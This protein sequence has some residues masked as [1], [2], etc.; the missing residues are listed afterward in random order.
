MSGITSEELSAVAGILLSL[1]FSYIPGVRE[2]FG[3][4]EPTYKRLVMLGLLLVSALGIFS[5]SCLQ[6]PVLKA[7]TCDQAG[8]WELGRVFVAALIANQ[9]V[10]TAS[11]KIN[12]G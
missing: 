12:K 8:A 11:P 1:G 4:M 10:F 6:S 9:A 2:R 5:L 7:I 3:S